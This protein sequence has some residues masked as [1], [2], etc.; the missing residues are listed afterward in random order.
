MD[1]ELGEMDMQNERARGQE[2]NCLHR[3]TSN[4]AWLSSVPHRLYGTELSQEELWDNLCLRYG[5]MPQDI[6]VTCNGCGKKLSFD[7]P[8]SCPKGALV[9]ERHDGATKGWVVLGAGA[10][11]PSAITYKPKINSRIVHGGEEQVQS[12]AG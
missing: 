5:L 3:A 6:P 4:G 12:A 2:R 9:L 10:L 8:L 1:V 7:H 11:A